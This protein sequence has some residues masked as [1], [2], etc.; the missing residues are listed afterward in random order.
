YNEYIEHNY[1][2]IGLNSVPYKY[3]TEGRANF[4]KLRG[5]LE[6]NFNYTGGENTRWAN[7]LLRFEHDVLIGDIVIIPTEGSSE[8]SIGEVVS[9]TYITDEKRSFSFEGNY[10]PYPEKRKKIK[11]IKQIR[12]EDFIGDTRSIISSH[13]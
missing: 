4:E 10:E 2:A 7:Q 9:N 5:F 12:R 3:I 8:F 6:S 11:W 13:Q 1:V